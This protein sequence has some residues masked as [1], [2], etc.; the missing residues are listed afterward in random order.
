MRLHVASTGTGDR[1]AL[2]IH[3]LMGDSGTW[4]AL[5]PVLVR[6]GYRVLAADLR[7]HGLSPRSPDGGYLPAGYADDLVESL[8]A[9]AEL[10]IGHSLGG[11]ALSL[12]IDRLRP[13]RAVYVDP[14]FRLPPGAGPGNDPLG[15]YADQ[16]TPASISAGNP[17]WS[18]ADIAAEV[19]GFSRFDRAATVARVKLGGTD[20]L[21]AT[22]AVPSLVQLADPSHL[23][24][25]ATAAILR[26]RGFDV[27]V[28]P[29][30]G[31]CIHRDDFAGF[32]ASLEGW[33]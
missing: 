29:G 2:L 19:L 33:L 3:G 27:Q 9:G 16:A 25:G 15:D 6:R 24:D 14:A 28:I 8:P 32:L 22:A 23:V 18:A 31:H 26:E 5:I 20:L 17:R 11:L 7:G 12:A 1:L 30:A 4:Q 10:A 21:P 13:A